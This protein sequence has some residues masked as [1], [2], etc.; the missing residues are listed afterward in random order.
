[1]ATETV[2]ALFDDVE[3]AW[4]AFLALEEAGFP[5][6]Q[7]SVVMRDRSGEVDETEAEA[8]RRLGDTL[9]T[10]GV[11]AGALA[12]G[13]GGLLGSLAGVVVAG[14]GPLLVLGPIGALFGAGVGAA[15]AGLAGVVGAGER[16]RT[17]EERINLGDVLILLSTSGENAERAAEVLTKAGGR[18][19][20]RIG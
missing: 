11:V 12:G 6:D 4:R 8:L 13:T 19:I 1:M 10:Q 16:A 20:D 7:I 2:L 15:A 5:R 3:Q 18:N 17:L 9:V 14:F